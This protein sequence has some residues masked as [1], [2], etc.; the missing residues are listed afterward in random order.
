M[1]KFEKLDVWQKATDFANVVYSKT[2][3]FSSDQRFALTNQMRRAAV[4]VSSNI[5]EGSSRILH[6]RIESA[7][8]MQTRRRMSCY[9]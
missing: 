9:A 4:S 2:K 5:A 3:S 1:F 8:L 7:Q 6:G